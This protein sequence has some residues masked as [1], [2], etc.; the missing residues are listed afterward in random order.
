MAAGPKG[1]LNENSQIPK[2]EWQLS[3]QG[4]LTGCAEQEVEA[5]ISNKSKTAK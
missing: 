4:S 3:G 1:V 2:V 5:G